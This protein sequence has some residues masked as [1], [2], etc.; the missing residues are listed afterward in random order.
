MLKDVGAAAFGLLVSLL[1]AMAVNETVR[2][3]LLASMGF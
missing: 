3:G 1:I 2:D